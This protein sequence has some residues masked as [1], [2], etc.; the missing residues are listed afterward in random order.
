MRRVLLSNGVMLLLLMLLL[1]DLV[2]ACRVL[3]VGTVVEGSWRIIAGLST[4]MWQMVVTRAWRNAAAIAATRR[5]LSGDTIVCGGGRRQH[6][7]L[8]AMKVVVGLIE[9]IGRR[10]RST[11]SIRP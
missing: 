7:L 8:L 4:R 6:I 10:L 5:P 9:R 3:K 11:T 2:T 1:H